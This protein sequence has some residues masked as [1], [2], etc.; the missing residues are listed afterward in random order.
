MTDTQPTHEKPFSENS[1]Y[2]PDAAINYVSD[3]I[4]DW[5]KGGRAR[6]IRCLADW[7]DPMPGT[8]WQQKWVAANADVEFPAE[9]ERSAKRYETVK[10]L[11]PKRAYEQRARVMRYGLTTLIWMGLLRPGPL[12]MLS[13]HAR[14]IHRDVLEEFETELDDVIKKTA[15]AVGITAKNAYTSK[16]ALAAMIAITGKPLAAITVEDWIT[17]E[18]T[19]SD[20]LAPYRAY[21]IARTQALESG[22]EP[23]ARPEGMI[24]DDMLYSLRVAYAAAVRADRVTPYSEVPPGHA[25]IPPSLDMALSKPKTIEAFL[26]PYEHEISG[27]LYELILAIANEF[28]SGHD[29]NTLRSVFSYLSIYMRAVRR[30]LPEHQSLVIPCWDATQLI[31]NLSKLDH[32][33][34]NTAGQRRGVHAILQVARRIHELAAVLVN[35]ED[36]P[37]YAQYADIVG[38]FPDLP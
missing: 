2:S 9:I 31:E 35:E 36:Y 26:E 27:R 5:T 11:S 7:L 25:P 13:R 37:E 6:G 32:H 1:P 17:V 19:R 15:R 38:R 10:N 23:P 3:N 12:L 18:R 8:T 4:S 28:Y 22:A 24:S 21:T 30:I 33:R 14:T 20:L 34:A 16:Y 29:F